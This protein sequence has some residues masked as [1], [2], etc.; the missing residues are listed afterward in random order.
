VARA[1]GA[2]GARSSRRD[3]ETTLVETARGLKY[4]RQHMPE[5]RFPL[6]LGRSRSCVSVRAAGLAGLLN[7]DEVARMNIV[8][9]TVNG[10]FPGNERMLA[11]ATH[12][13]NYA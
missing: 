2:I 9:V 13:I 12:V 3:S 4:F 11:N 8:D 7:L 5:R 10:N 1:G 6:R